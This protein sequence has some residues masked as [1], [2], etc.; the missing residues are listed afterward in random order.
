MEGDGSIF[1]EGTRPELGLGPGVV[2]FWHVAVTVSDMEEALRFYRDALGLEFELAY[3]LDGSIAGPIVGLEL[4][5]LEVVFLRVPGSEVR[6]ELHRYHGVERYPAACRPCDF[7]ASHFCLY[8]NDAQAVFD[9]AVGLG[10]GSRG[11]VISVADGP[12]AGAKVVYL[13]AP[14]GYHV[15]LYQKANR[16]PV[17]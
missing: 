11:P 12:H 14:D 6:I 16:G 2:G 5:I 7:A 1:R 3:R 8:V 4:G 13:I 10:F 17:E 15:E 9:R